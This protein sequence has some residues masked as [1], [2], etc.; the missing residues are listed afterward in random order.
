LG[1]L[2]AFVNFDSSSDG[3]ALFV[4]VYSR[5]KGSS[6]G[7][8]APSSIEM[9]PPAGGKAQILY[10]SST[11]AIPVLRV[12]NSNSL[13][14]LVENVDGDTSQNGLWKMNIDGTGLTR[15]TIFGNETDALFNG[16]AQLPWSNF[17]RDN[18]LYGIWTA[19]SHGLTSTNSLL[20]GSLQKAV[21]TTI[22][23]AD[24]AGTQLAIVGWTTI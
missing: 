15:L 13:C 1:D 3:K 12:I 16:F 7:P 22:A 8:A 23:S 6:D 9:L 20:V 21:P 4:S 18:S 19:T 17:S 14:L 24:A 10:A 5:F 11:L 2:S